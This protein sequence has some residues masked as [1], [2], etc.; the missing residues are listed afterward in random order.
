VVPNLGSNVVT[1][2]NGSIPD[3]LQSYILDMRGTGT[4][5]RIISS[6]PLLVRAAPPTTPVTQGIASPGPPLK[7]VNALATTSITSTTVTGSIHTSP[8]SQQPITTT[9]TFDVLSFMTSNTPYSTSSFPSPAKLTSA[10][11][12]E[13]SPS[14]SLSISPIPMTSGITNGWS[15]DHRTLV[16]V[17][18]TVLGFVGLAL[19]LGALFLLLRYRRGQS[20][21]CHRGRDAINDDEIL[22]WRRNNFD[23]K[24]PQPALLA[25]GKTEMSTTRLGNPPTWRWAT[26][27]TLGQTVLS[28]S[29][30]YPGSPS[31]LAKAPNARKGLT[32][33][34]IPGAD[35]FV[36][37]I[38][39]Q[40]SR[41]S[42][43]PPGHTRSKSRRSSMSAKSVGSFKWQNRERISS[44]SK[45]EDSNFSWFDPEDESVV[46]QLRTDR[47]SS[48]NR[49]S[50]FDGLAMG[51]L[52][53]R[54][55]PRHDGAKLYIGRA[56]G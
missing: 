50:V 11:L 46:S 32:D 10:T 31:F 55:Q 21:F 30:E 49:T 41:L 33:E 6:L 29:S 36:G 23:H 47:T 51:G 56:I 43:P 9:N 35:P 28:P 37:T 14:T 19:I 16:I 4:A 20:P 26:P 5:L 54:P 39:R 38:K 52:S 22:S 24:R 27:P 3:L 8:S 12:A 45:V 2:G 25:T 44:D 13:H 15:S 53:P 48:S 7:G 42:K 34:T 1:P 40:S 18:S 17:L